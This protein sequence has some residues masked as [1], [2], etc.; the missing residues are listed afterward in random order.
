[1]CAPREDSDQPVHP[2][3]LIS[4]FAVH[5]NKHWALNYL[6]SA[7]WRLWSHWAD[8]QVGLSSLGVHVILFV[9]SVA[10]MTSQ[11]YHSAI[12]KFNSIS[13]MSKFGFYQKKKYYQNAFCGFLWNLNSL[14]QNISLAIKLKQPSCLNKPNVFHF[15]LLRN[16]K[17]GDKFEYQ[18]K[19]A[20]VLKN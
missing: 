8:A 3:S 17:C 12:L 13:K 14:S 15:F 16:E 5:M 4:V 7:H 9:L 18:R 10:H 6:L 20:L 1:M 2:P 11:V 19:I